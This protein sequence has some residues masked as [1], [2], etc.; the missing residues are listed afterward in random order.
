MSP[1]R[2]VVGSILRQYPAQV[3]FTQNDYVVDAL[4]PD[5]S[6]QPFGEAV[7]PRRGWGDRLVTDAHGA[8]STC[9]DAAVEA[10]P[11]ADQVARSLIHGNA[12]VIWRAIHSAVG[13]AVNGPL[14]DRRF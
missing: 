5:R 11:I 13:F 12:A 6:D 2:I 1:Q 7:L 4:A 10:I 3:C 14:L 8:H 9:D